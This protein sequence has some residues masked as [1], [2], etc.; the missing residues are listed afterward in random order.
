MYN[1]F[2]ITIKVHRNV[3]V[4]TEGDLVES[5]ILVKFSVAS[6]SDVVLCGLL[7]KRCVDLRGSLRGRLKEACLNC[8]V[9]VEII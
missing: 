1:E 8:E 7:L 4:S 6:D 9:K 2:V 5:G 3:L